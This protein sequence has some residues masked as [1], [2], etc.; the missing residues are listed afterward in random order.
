MQPK[1]DAPHPRGL[2]PLAGPWETATKAVPSL[3]RSLD[4]GPEARE[5]T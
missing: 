5:R 2:G 1:W 4:W 3:V